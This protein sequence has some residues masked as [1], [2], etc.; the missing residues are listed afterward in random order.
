MNYVCN[1]S[2]KL[3]STNSHGLPI[4]P[5]IQWTHVQRM[6]K[7]LSHSA[8]VE[9]FQTVALYQRSITHNTIQLTVTGASISSRTW[10]GPLPF[11]PFPP[12]RSFLPVPS[13]SLTSP[14]FLPAL[15]PFPYPFTLI[16]LSSPRQN[17][18]RHLGKH[19]N[20]CSGV[21]GRDPAANALH[22]F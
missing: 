3:V 12:S 1:T 7:R 14:T 8:S 6:T 13:P 2:R 10:S 4:I 22:A 9:G 11:P 20:L 18:A 15:S 17:P 16:P 21:R 19:C 5:G